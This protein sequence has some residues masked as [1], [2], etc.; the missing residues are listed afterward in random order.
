MHEN[1]SN[2]KRYFETF[3][4]SGCGEYSSEIQKYVTN[5]ELPLPEEKERLHVCWNEVFKTNSYPVLSSLVRPCLSIFTGPMV[6]RS[7]SMMNDIDSRSGYM[8]SE[9]YSAIMTIKYSLKSSK[10]A[11]LKFNRK[12]ILRD[13]VDSTLSYYMRISSSRYKKCLKTKRDK[14]LLKKKNLSS[15]KVFSEVTK[16]RR[17]E[18]VHKEI[19]IYLWPYFRLKL[20]FIVLL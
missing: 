7:F 16:K 17:K 10:S 20:K 18:T 2:L 9:T 14:M 1:L 19:I 11:V 12:D 6:E 15:K 8:E 3:L 13:H 5:S 4:S